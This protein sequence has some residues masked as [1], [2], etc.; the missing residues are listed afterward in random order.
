MHSVMAY[1]RLAPTPKAHK[2]GT[3][4]PPRWQPLQHT[5][6]GTRGGGG[7]HLPQEAEFHMVRGGTSVSVE[8]NWRKI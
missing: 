1:T 3:N 8:R 6:S 5:E 2:N 7:G 4:K